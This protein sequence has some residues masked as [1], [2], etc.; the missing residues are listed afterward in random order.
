MAYGGIGPSENLFRGVILESGSAT[1]STPIPHPD[2]APWQRVYDQIVNATGY[3][4]LLLNN[5]ILTDL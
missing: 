4:H 1:E 3:L 5:F 2:F